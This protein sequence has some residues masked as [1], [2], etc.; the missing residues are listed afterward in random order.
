V[1]R[2]TW[3]I[4]VRLRTYRRRVRAYAVT[5]KLKI[6]AIAIAIGLAFSAGAIAQSMSKAEYQSG[7]D[8]IAAGYKSAKAACAPLS[9]SH[10]DGTRGKIRRQICDIEAKGKRDVAKAE[11][12]A[13]YSPGEQNRHAVN[14]AKAK[15]HYAVAKKTCEEADQVKLVCLEKAKAADTS[16]M[17]D[18]EA[19]L[20]SA[21][22][23]TPAKDTPTVSTSKP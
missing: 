12:E 7:K 1:L 9:G 21:V 2:G 17:A 15:A 4:N 11:L 19:A 5:M 14:V 20:K 3:R 13:R 23:G 18:A 22:A 8:G 6:N 16:A 10:R